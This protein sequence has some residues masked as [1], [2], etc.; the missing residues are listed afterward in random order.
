MFTPN[1]MMGIL[2]QIFPSVCL[3][4][5]IW[6]KQLQVKPINVYFKYQDG[7]ITTDF[8]IFVSEFSNME[9]ELQVEPIN[10]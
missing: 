1:T 4:F 9:K 7:N 10:V 8:P 3:S 2:P 6:E 5:P